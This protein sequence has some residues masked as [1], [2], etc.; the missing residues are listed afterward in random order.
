MVEAE[1][2]LGR[3]AGVASVRLGATGSVASA[4]RT[5]LREAAAAS[6]SAIGFMEPSVA[7]LSIN[8]NHGFDIAIKW[9]NARSPPPAHLSRGSPARFVLPRG[10]GAVAHSARRV[11]ADPLARAAAR[12]PPARPR[13]RRGKSHGGRRA[14][15]AAPGCPL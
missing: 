7:L 5:A 10:G 13:P 15:S 6:M 9:P 11:A 3:D 14:P 4:P 8:S 2:R 1:R 12:D